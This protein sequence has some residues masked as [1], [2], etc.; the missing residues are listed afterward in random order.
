MRESR[1]VRRTYIVFR[2]NGDR[3]LPQVL[4]PQTVAA[5][6]MNPT[7]AQHIYRFRRNLGQSH[8]E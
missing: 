8:S 5:E 2:P 1:C 3:F 6:D 7:L 4:F